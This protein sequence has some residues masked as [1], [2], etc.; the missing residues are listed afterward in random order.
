MGN[1]NE[2]TR[3][4][5]I[6]E[7]VKKINKISRKIYLTALNAMLMAR[8]A[9]GAGTGYARVTTDLRSF[10]ERLEQGM[11]GLTNITSSTVLEVSNHVKKRRIQ[12]TFREALRQAEIRKSGIARRLKGLK[13]VNVMTAATQRGF[14]DMGRLIERLVHLCRQGQNV[15]V[16]AKV[17]A[18]HIG[19]YTDILHGIGDDVANSVD[20]VEVILQ[21]AYEIIRVKGKAA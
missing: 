18:M 4:V 7:D 16:L 19:S 3:L 8:R 9:G 2:L 21:S 11:Y 10:S 17:E 5:E 14:E 1:Y 13:Q 6:R 15:A 20:Q 12:D